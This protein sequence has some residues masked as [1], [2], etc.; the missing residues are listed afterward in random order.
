MGQM[1]ETKGSLLLAWQ[2]RGKHCLVI[3][4]GDVALS[5]IHHL[6]VAQA[7]I[8]V[9]TG[10]TK[11][12]HPEILD[13]NSQGKIHNLILRNYESE[14]LRM[15]EDTTSK[16]DYTKIGPG[17]YEEVSCLINE[18]FA[19][20]CCCIDDYELSTK[21]YYQCKL[22]RLPVNIADKPPLCDF[23]FG[24]M[25]NQ[26]NLQIMI[27]TNGKSPRLSKLIKDNI[28]REFAGV[29]VNNAIE[30]LGLIR[31][32]LRE[33]ILIDDDL[34]T[35]DTRM[36]WIKNLTDFFT[37]RQWSSIKLTPEG[38]DSE[39]K[40][41]DKIVNCFPNYPPREFDEFVKFICT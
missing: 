1:S 17:D 19:C 13:L 6:I 40:Q 8:T 3:G 15:Y 38:S 31:S 18:T 35:I 20:V 11:D 28:A 14:D 9:V 12:V 32:R 29:D 22:L 33:L 30:N 2:V 39:Y 34:V 10:V 27:S 24:S 7:R 21:I 37:I 25:I 4:A 36:S 23:Y 5:R 41:V 26:D 16:L